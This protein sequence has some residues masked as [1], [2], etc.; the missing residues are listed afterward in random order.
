[1]R[2]RIRYRIR[3]C[4]VAFF[5]TLLLQDTLCL[6]A[7]YPF[8]LEPLEEFDPLS[9]F[10]MTGG[11][12]VWFVRPQLF[13]SCSLCP[14]GQM[15]DKAT[16]REFSLVFFSTFEPISL[17]P[18][19]YM[20]RS[21]IPMLYERAA[22]QLPTLYVCPVEN[23]LGSVPLMP[24]YLKGN[25]HNTIPHSLRNNVPAG[26]AA[27]SRPNSGTGSRLFEVNMWMWRYGRALPR[28]ISVED[29]EE[30]RRKRVQ[31]SRRKGAETLKR[32]R[33]AV[34]ARQAAE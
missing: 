17:T 15:A 13:F 16:H 1:M 27:D 7:P 20:Q 24:C 26:A 5:L 14:T 4:K 33:L 19:S 9:D 12:D 8:R 23:V 11:D 18:D 29:A 34:A 31:E 28:K 25:Q 21:G 22:S 6:V 32:R 10:D 2:C 30:M 3:Y